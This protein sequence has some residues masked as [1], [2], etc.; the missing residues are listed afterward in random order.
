MSVTYMENDF[1]IENGILKS[2]TGRQEQ[3]TVP[4]EVRI[5]GEN[6]FK[7]CV[8]LRKVVL[9]S[10]LEHILAGAFK[11]CRRLKEIA[12]PPGVTY[13]GEYAFHRCHSLE[14]VSLPP[15]V[16]ELGDCTFLYCDSL[17]RVKIPGVLH[18]GKQVFVNDVMLREL[19]ISPGLRESCLCDVFTGCG[20]ISEVA[21]SDGRRFVFPNAVEVVAGEMAVPGLVRAIAVDVLRM[22]EL[23]GR[24]LA[25][26]LTNLKHVEIPEGIE[27]I[28]KS[29]F[30]D[31]RGIIS[32]QFP[33][34]L[35]E[36]ES[37]AF[38]N[39][40][41]LE[42]VAFRREGIVVHED[43]FQNCSALREVRMPEGAAFGI[44]GIAGLSGEDIP[45]LVRT[46]RKQVLGNFLLSGSVLLKYLGKESRVVVP[47]GVVRIAEEAFAGN[48]G[49]DRVILPDSVESIGAG[50]F[51]DCLVLQAVNFP[52]GLRDL[53]T[54]AFENC[55]KLLRAPL[56][57]GLGQV[58]EKAFKRCRRLKE[59]HLGKNLRAIGEEAFYGCLALGEVRF[60]DSLVSLGDLAFYRCKALGEVRLLPGMEEVGN[61]A[62]AQS[63]VKGV[64]MEGSGRGYGRDI[65]FQCL[66]LRRVVLEEGV[67]HIPDRLAYGCSA[68]EQ[69]ALPG[70]LESVGRHVWEG[71]PFLRDWVGKQAGD[72]TESGNPTEPGDWTESGKRTEPGNPTQNKAEG[73][74][75]IF[76]DGRH[77]RGSVSLPEET[78]IVAGGA[79]YGNPFLTAIRFS[80]HVTWIGEAALKG[81]TNLRRV[82]WPKT[83]TTAESE[84]F[85]GCTQL[86]T[87]TLCPDRGRAELQDM[88]VPWKAVKN[89]AFY[90]CRKLSRLLWKDI[91]TVGKEAF[92]GCAALKPEG[93]DSLEWVGELAFAGMEGMENA[94]AAD[95]QDGGAEEDGRADRDGREDTAGIEGLGAGET[96]ERTEVQDARETQ[97]T[98]DGAVCQDKESRDG[99]NQDRE[100]QNRKPRCG[101]SGLCIVG[102]IVVSG[103]GCQGEVQVPEGIT[104]IAPYAFSANRRITGLV[105]P[106]TLRSIGEGAFWGCSGLAH[107]RFPAAPCAVG[108]R[109]FE[110]CTGIRSVRLRA[111]SLGASAFARCLS[112]EWAE[113][114][115]L[116]LLEK[117]LFEG[118]ENLKECVCGQVSAVGDSCFSGCSTL[119]NFD[120]Q[121]ITEIGS[122][123][124]QDCDNLREIGL[125]D[126]TLVCPHGFQ[127][128]GRLA[129]LVLAGE[130]GSLELGE[131]AFSGCTAL[132]QVVR[133]GRLWELGEY[134]DILSESLP[135]PVRLIFHSALSCF[136]VEKEEI[137]LGYSGLGRI[138]NIPRGIRRIQAEVFLN[139]LMLEEINI[140]ETVEYIGA[141]AF[142]KTAWMEKRRAESPMV[143]VNHMLL[144]GSCCRGKVVVPEDIRLVCGWAFAGGL[145][146]EKIRFLSDRVRVESYA[147]R[148]CIFLKELVL[149]DG[150]SVVFQGISDRKKELPPVAEQAV[151]DRLNCFKTDENDVLTECT[152]NISR[153]LVAEGITAIGDG[154]FQ[155]GNLLTEV[156][157]PRTV[158]SIGRNSFAGC[159]WLQRVCGAEHVRIIGT[160][161]FS[162]CGSLEAVELAE[163]LR[164]I[165]LG[166]FENC[167]SLREIVVPEGVEELPERV[168]FRCHSLRKVR[169]PSTLKRIGREAFAFCR[170]LEALAIPEGVAVGECAFAGTLNAK[171]ETATKY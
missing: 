135:E 31:K 70:T 139:R 133:R 137:L 61:L 18:L 154:V 97:E 147:F 92:S 38:R 113:I 29:A 1:Q 14:S 143:T 7:G 128:C 41:S 148:N 157:L 82:T 163:S 44:E 105:L 140:P 98:A 107:V 115:G 110:K 11:G 10:G 47:Q 149:A 62:F 116:S 51:R 170:S 167:T 71:T 27:K 131:Y 165:G 112:L 164:E 58:G 79:F 151:W 94:Y 109:A 86:E 88:D 81:C 77:V 150:T 45:A 142:H 160:R 64:R 42:T 17:T 36:I 134:R 106:E 4:E 158:T 153:L 28:G 169:L 25:K 100:S 125:H 89:R 72:W 87:I 141:R 114:T 66:H 60:P 55:V 57:E 68:L 80:D 93:A 54:G 166:A 15:S 59:L 119:E 127:D 136:Q 40:I 161:A 75:E 21:F 49:V 48:E 124:F 32:V 73:Q 20:R 156:I 84:V 37:R 145:G 24:C 50:A 120:F 53:G 171:Q 9:P 130:E 43:G 46:V 90:N 74:N 155:D 63:G 122:Y 16:K 30:F 159:K 138:L 5:V 22:M 52:A 108:S 35:Q 6:A 168:F 33:A 34:T 118:C 96:A 103:A 67:R 2:Y 13:V 26:F 19:E 162:G 101:T 117:R 111:H 39:C 123:A 95:R 12:V 126:H 132:R 121:T 152:G 65:F 8:S 3:V 99:E 91:R 146:I 102:T 56:P 85:S 83:V 76:W 144:D 69:V 104:A 129:R 23:E 78:R